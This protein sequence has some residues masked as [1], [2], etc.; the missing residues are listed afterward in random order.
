MR[1]SFALFAAFGLLT[2]TI[3]ASAASTSAKARPELS[4][5]QLEIMRT[6]RSVDG[7]IDKA[8]HDEF[9]SLMPSIMRSSPS[10]RRLLEELFSDVGEAGHDFQE[11]TWLSARES[12]DAQRI[13]RTKAYLGARKAVLNASS[14]RGY[15]SSIRKSIASAERLL[16]AAASGAPLDFNGGRAFITSDLVEHVLSGLHASDFRVAKLVDPTWS[17][18]LTEFKYSEAHVS[19]LA[20]TP[21]ISEQKLIR[22][23]EA[24]DVEIVSLSQS[25]NSS[26][27]VGISFAATGGRY[28]HPVKSLI[29]N[30]RAAIEGAGATGRSPVVTKWRGL[31]SATATGAARTSEGDVFV[32]VRVVEVP[33]INGVL[34]FMVVSQLSAAEANTQRSILEDSSRILTP[35]STAPK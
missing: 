23:P 27:N 5:R 25:L 33:R 31:D 28:V 7:Y 22:N 2:S 24:R 30:A 3:P 20:L 10:A 12:L 32:S 14:N 16:A 34:Q 17:D 19:V 21:F 35:A 9:W 11:Q 13:V 15:Q 1:K 26:T 18:R 4:A 29:S 6:I 8:L